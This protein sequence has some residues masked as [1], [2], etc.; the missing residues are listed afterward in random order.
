MGGGAWHWSCT[1][2]LASRVLELEGVE[3]STTLVALVAS[4]IFVG[5]LGAY[6]FD[7]TVCQ[8]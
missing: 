2:Y 4:S 1:V 3:K 8:E 6:A 5:T 7:E